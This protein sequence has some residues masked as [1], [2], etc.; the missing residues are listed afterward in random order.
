MVDSTAIWDGVPAF[1]VH[2]GH[3]FE[4][5]ELVAAVDRPPMLHA[6]CHCG[7]VLDVAEARF[8]PCPKCDGAACV[9]CGGTGRIVDHAALEWRLPRR[10]WP[11]R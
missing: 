8:A 2:P 5:F 9:R 4:G 7:E 1:H 11:T 3:E 10:S 6:R